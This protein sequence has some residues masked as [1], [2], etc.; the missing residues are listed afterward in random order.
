VSLACFGN[1]GAL[2]RRNDSPAEASRPFDKDRDGIVLSDGGAM[3]V[4]EP[5]TA[6]RRRGARPYAEVAGCGFSSDASHMVIPSPDP[7][8]AVAAVRS[9]LRDAGASAERIDYVNAHATSTPVGDSGEARV[10]QTVLGEAVR[11]VPVSA[12]KSM[13]G[14]ALS[15]AAALGAIAC[16]TAL[17]RQ[18][19]PPTI[20]LDDAGPECALCHVPHEARDHRVRL[21]L[22]NS[23]GFGGS[24]TCI[25]F[26]KVA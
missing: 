9:A 3:F 23:F 24:N 17:E 11:T 25:A 1:L 12:S 8:P 10:I 19:I 15:G 13:T 22:A 5:A 2:S 18:A 4:L 26:R 21:A 7:G 16:L 20:N 6:A 14:H